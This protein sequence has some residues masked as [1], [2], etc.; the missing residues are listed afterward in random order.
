MLAT[1]HINNETLV[2]DTRCRQGYA[3]TCCTLLF[4]IKG[5]Q[6]TEAGRPFITPSPLTTRLVS[7]VQRM[8]VP[9]PDGTSHGQLLFLSDANW[10]TGVSLDEQGSGK[11]TQYFPVPNEFAASGG[12]DEVLPV[13]T[14]DDD[15]IFSLRGELAV[16]RNG[17]KHEDVTEL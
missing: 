10:V 7:K 15:I 9:R 13:R 6:E 17:L 5:V 8:V 1:I 3:V 11:C 2:M 12:G 14:V 4:D 16:I